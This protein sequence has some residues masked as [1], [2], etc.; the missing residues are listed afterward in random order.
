MYKKHRLEIPGH[1]SGFWYVVKASDPLHTGSLGAGLILEPGLLVEALDDDNCIIEFN[2]KA[3]TINT[4][5]RANELANIPCS[6]INVIS[7]YELE[8]GYGISAGI[9]LGGL[10]FSLMKKGFRKSWFEIGRYA[11]IAEV[12]NVTGYGDV[13]AEISGGGVELRRMPGAPGIGS[14]DKIPVSKHIKVITIEM[15]RYSTKKMFDKYGG[16]IQDIGEK[17]Y[18]SFIEDPSIEKFGEISHWF[19]LETGMMTYNMDKKIKNVLFEEL[20][21]GNVLDFFI[22][23]GLLVVI[24]EESGYLS[25]YEDLKKLGDPKVFSLN[26]SGCRLV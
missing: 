21:N 7:P 13:I 11:H 12:E 18:N 9:T 8:V 25:T 15:D 10:F 1:I 6:D 2:D 26:F 20:R 23:K 16:K 3:I 22:K 14:V 4:Y 5:I 24:T 19:S 17:A